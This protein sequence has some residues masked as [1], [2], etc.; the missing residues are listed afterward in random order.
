MW[1][2]ENAQK[3]NRKYNR[4]LRVAALA[5]LGGKCVRYGFDDPRA[6]QIDHINGGGTKEHSGM[7][8][9]TFHLKIIS[10]AEGYQLLCANCNQIKRY[11][12]N[13]VR[14]INKS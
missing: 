2:K 4:K 7:S 12:N 14:G 11:E 10:G 1:T 9:Q 3:S 8:P 6:L 13:E 5:F